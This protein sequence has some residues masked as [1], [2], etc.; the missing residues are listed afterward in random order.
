MLRRLTGE[1]WDISVELRAYSCTKVN[2]SRCS[3]RSS[4]SYLFLLDVHPTVSQ[5]APT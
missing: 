2:L 3:G 4:P 5:T 1:L